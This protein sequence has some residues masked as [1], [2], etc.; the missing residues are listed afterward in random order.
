MMNGIT[1]VTI[2]FSMELSSA[3]V[4]QFFYKNLIPYGLRAAGQYVWPF[5]NE[6]ISPASRNEIRMA[7]TTI[8]FSL[9]MLAVAIVLRQHI[10]AGIAPSIDHG[11][12]AS[13]IFQCLLLLFTERL[14]FG[15]VIQLHVLRYAWVG[16]KT[17][18]KSLPIAMCF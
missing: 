7:T 16:P 11:S 2:R 17:N 8:I 18:H 14:L 5:Q 9:A 4:L 12:S 1:S 13:L 3:R 10:S 6:G 15:H